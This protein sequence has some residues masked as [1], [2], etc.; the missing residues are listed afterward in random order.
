[1]I[2]IIAAMRAEVDALRREMATVCEREIDGICFWEGTLA[3]TDCVLMLSGVGKGH[4]ALATTLLLK[5]YDVE[6]VW[7]IGTAGGLQ[8]GEQVL[9][10][11]ISEQIIQHDYDTSALDGEAGIGLQFQADTRWV[12]LCKNVCLETKE[13]YHCGLMLSGDQFISEPTQIHAL[14]QRY[15]QALCAE[16]EA[17]AIAQV[18]THFHIPFVILRSLSDIA[19]QD[20]NQLDFHE[21]V[22]RASRRSAH[23]CVSL[24]KKHKESSRQKGENCV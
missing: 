21:Y 20:G 3:Q 19:L 15:P 23:L 17:G 9:D 5:N 8:E 4:A 12:T 6:A 22:H 14:K 10:L 7:N 24:M 1:M 11:V 16:M 18:C 13:R 2:G